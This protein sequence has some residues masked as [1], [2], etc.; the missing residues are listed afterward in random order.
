MQTAVYSGYCGQKTFSGEDTERGR[1]LLAAVNARYIHSNLAVYSL[2]AYARAKG[3]ET[4]LAEYTINH[5]KEEILR[6]IY[7][8]HP[9]AVGFSCYIWN[10]DFIREL[11]EELHKIM[12]QLPIWL[13]GPEVSWNPEE[14]LEEMP[15]VTGIMTGEGEQTFAQLTAFYEEVRRRSTDHGLSD[16]MEDGISADA[17]AALIRIPGLCCR[18]RSGRILRT[19]SRELL[20]MDELVFPYENLDEYANRII[21]YESSRGCP[22][23][24]SYCLSS[25]EKKLRFRSLSLV[26]AE[27]EFFMREKPAQVKFVDRTFN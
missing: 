3:V 27:L 8:R 12:P 2:R 11:A 21:Y 14:R 23:T 15:F 6:D 19:A 7:L 17:A 13:G 1:F 5:Q 9:G 25:V 20:S 22:F 10:M 4:D 18:D 26:Y 16:D 24:C